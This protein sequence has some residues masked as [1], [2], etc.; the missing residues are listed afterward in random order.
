MMTGQYCVL[1]T[2]SHSM[3]WDWP[4][5]SDRWADRRNVAI[6]IRSADVMTVGRKAAAC[7]SQ[8]N[9]AWSF[10]LDASAASLDCRHLR[11]HHLPD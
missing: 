10:S 5:L 9:V 4:Q 8:V 7:T 6:L 11:Y 3:H 1:N 2:V